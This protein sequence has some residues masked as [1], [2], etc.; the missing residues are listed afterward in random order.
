MLYL[1]DLGVVVHPRSEWPYVGL[2]YGTKYVTPR[3]PITFH[4]TQDRVSEIIVQ[5]K[6]DALRNGA[7]LAVEVVKVDGHVWIV[8]GHHTLV[9]FLLD[10]VPPRLA[11]YGAGP[12]YVDPPRYRRR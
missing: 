12:H 8:D 2:S 9:A 11:V 4:T 1:A 5:E 7:P 3:Y 10:G 6:R